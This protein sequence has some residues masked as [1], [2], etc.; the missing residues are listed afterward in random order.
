MKSNLELHSVA[1]GYDGT[2][3]INDLSLSLSPGEIGCLLG[4]SGSGKSTLLRAIAGLHSITAGSIKMGEQVLD[5]SYRPI[6][7]EARKI[8]LVFQDYALFPHMTVLQNIAYG[9][10]EPVDDLIELTGLQP[11]THRLPHQLSGGQQQRVA[12]A[13]ALAM[14]PSLVLMDEP[15][16]NL[17]ANLRDDLSEQTRNIV[18]QSGT[19]ALVVSHDQHE[20]FAI[21]DKIGIM[22]QGS[23]LQWGSPD[24]VVSEPSSLQVAQFIGQA[25]VLDTTVDNGVAT[26]AY[27]TFSTHYNDG[28]YWLVARPNHIDLTGNQLTISI[29]ERRI[30]PAGA[31]LRLIGDMGEVNFDLPQVEQGTA[32]QFSITKSHCLIQK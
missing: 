18:K 25:L 6:P 29:A 17:D 7:A 13:R 28:S 8:G 14:R 27:G 30:T 10:T 15:F 21:A 12:L 9:A 24:Q 23:L 16:S 4:A 31:R 3:L 20:A 11:L 2:A 5:D 19:M 22:H 1:A 32:L 26:T